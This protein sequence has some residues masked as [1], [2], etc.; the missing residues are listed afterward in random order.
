ML[1]IGPAESNVLRGARFGR[2]SFL[3]GRARFEPADFRT[4]IEY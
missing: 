1:E 4:E 2:L 3:D